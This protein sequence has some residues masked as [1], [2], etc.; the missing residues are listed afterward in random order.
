MGIEGD[1]VLL[2]LIS[3]VNKVIAGVK[4]TFRIF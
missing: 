3:T 2:H 1:H 4:I